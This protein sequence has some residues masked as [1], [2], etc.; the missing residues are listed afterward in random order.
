VLQKIFLAIHILSAAPTCA[1]L[2]TS[3]RCVQTGTDQ[4]DWVEPMA[5]WGLLIFLASFIP[6]TIA[7]YLGY[8]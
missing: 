1:A 2:F 7:R 4:P 8:R 6:P 5:R 3:D